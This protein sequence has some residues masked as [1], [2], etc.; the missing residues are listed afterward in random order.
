M[1]KNYDVRNYIQKKFLITMNSSIDLS[2][3]KI[4]SLKILEFIKFLINN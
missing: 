3:L 1:K 2:K 4:L